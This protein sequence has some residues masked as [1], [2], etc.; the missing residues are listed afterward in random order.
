MVMWVKW[1]PWRFIIRY[2][3][4]THGFIDPL[5]LVAKLRRFAKPSEVGEPIE[6]LRAGMVFHARGLINSRVIQHN[7]DWIWPYWIERQ[8]DPG[9]ESFIPR[10]FSI[11]HINLTHRNWTALGWPDY[12]EYP[13]V[14]PRGLVTPL[15]DG[16]SVDNWIVT[17]AGD[18][19]LPSRSRDCRQALVQE[20]VPAIRTETRETD[21][22]LASRARVILENGR[23]ILCLELNALASQ[24]AWAV[25]ALRPYNPEG[26]S[27]IHKI[28]LTSDRRGWRVDETTAIDF[29]TPAERHA[30]SDYHAGDVAL[31]LLDREEQTAVSCNVGMATAAALFRL[32]PNRSRRIQARIP[33]TASVPTG[34][35]AS[36]WERERR[37][38]CRLEVTDETIRALYDTALTSLILHSPGDVYPGPYTYRRFWFRDAAFILHGLLCAGLTERAESI[39]DRFPERQDHQGYF[40]S[41]EGEWDANGEALWILGRFC[42]LT[43]RPPKPEWERAIRRGGRWIL[44]KR[45]AENDSLH[46]GLMPAGFSAEHLGPNDYYYWDDFWSVAGLD[47]AARLTEH[48]DPELARTFAAETER[49]HSAIDRSLGLAA[50]RLDRPAMP[51]APSRRL[52]AGAIGSLAAGYPLQL[53]SPRDPRLLDTVEFLLDRCFVKGGFF[54]D[55][56]HSGINPYL[57][58]HVAQVLLRAGDTRC[59]DLIKTIAVLASP[60]GQWPEAIHPRTLGGC[61]GDGQHVWAS[62]EWLLMIRNCFVRKEGHQLILAG[63]VSL[64][65]LE[66][67]RPAR[68]GPSPTAFGAVRVCVEEIA[69]GRIR[70]SWEGRWHRRQPPIIVHLPGYEPCAVEPG[71]REVVL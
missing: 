66:P 15:Y 46:A 19:L 17:D 22:A 13:L 8:F 32:E 48:F 51:A 64:S 5:A 49:F 28:E 63:G 60:T 33:L 47:N 55:M 6:L 35:N 3:A 31:T 2:L 7:L 61:M 10:A 21:L 68:F 26:I 39:L 14:D 42:E 27:F 53:Y 50:A 25:L 40:H 43:G 36:A 44:R 38:A 24:P 65:W 57:T 11:S 71:Q 62:A 59:L 1:F 67:G 34:L 70:V 69:G 4:R 18:R 20:P 52:D 37:Q 16:W 23:P 12:G 56:I 54:Q 9:D 58:L 30:T 45:L 29:D 41:Q